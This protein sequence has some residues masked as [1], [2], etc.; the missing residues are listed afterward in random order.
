MLPPQAHS[1]ALQEPETLEEELAR[2]G[3]ENEALRTDKRAMR[4]DVDRLTEER[5]DDSTYDPA[6]GHE[7]FC[8]HDDLVIRFQFVEDHCDTHQVKRICLVRGIQRSSFY[9]WREGRQAR[10]AKQ[11]A[12]Q[13]LLERIR[14]HHH[15]WDRTYRHR[16]IAAE[17]PNTTYVG[18]ITY[19]P[20]GTERTFL[21]RAPSLMS[22]P[23]G[24]KDGRSPITCAPAWS[25]TP[26]KPRWQSGDHWMM[27]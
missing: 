14:A 6:E 20:Y 11:E 24:W 23:S 19:L 18:D 22:A 21:Y 7:T 15:H 12:D 5:V 27:L 17:A 26:S 13:L 4:T 16:R 1:A 8:V 25:K 3:V 9:Q 10:P 2:R